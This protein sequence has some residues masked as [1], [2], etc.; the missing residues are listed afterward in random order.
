MGISTQIITVPT[1]LETARPR[2]TFL[3]TLPGHRMSLVELTRDALPVMGMTK[4]DANLWHCMRIN[5]STCASRAI[6]SN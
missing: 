1:L 4:R 3:S 5:V 6:C 2:M